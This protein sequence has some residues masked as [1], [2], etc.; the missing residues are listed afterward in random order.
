MKIL[1]GRNFATG[2]EDPDRG[3]DEQVACEKGEN[4]ADCPGVPQKSHGAS[5]ENGM[6]PNFSSQSLKNRNKKTLS[7]FFSLY[8]LGNRSHSGT[9]LYASLQNR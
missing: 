7:R 1:L 2:T 6:S 9:D 4:D 8:G 3:M 5:V